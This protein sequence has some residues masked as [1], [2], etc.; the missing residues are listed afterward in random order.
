MLLLF[1]V[2]LPRT[3]TEHS[4]FAHFQRIITGQFL[5]TWL[6]EKCPHGR[7]KSDCGLGNCEL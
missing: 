7:K 5:E 2:R 6:I 1:A 3:G 4:Y